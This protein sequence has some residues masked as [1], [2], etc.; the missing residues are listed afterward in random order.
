MYPNVPGGVY[1]HII[2]IKDLLLESEGKKIIYPSEFS[3]YKLS[4]QKNPVIQM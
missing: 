4:L 1:S 2:M 3:F